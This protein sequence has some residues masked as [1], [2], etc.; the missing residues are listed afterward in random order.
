MDS[1]DL[2]ALRSTDLVIPVM[3]M[4]GVGKSSFITRLADREAGV[5]HGL[6]SFT[7]GIGVYRVK[8]ARRVVYLVDT[9]GFDDT[10][11][12]DVE[13]F[14]ELAFLFGQLYR[15]GARLGGILYLHRITDNRATGSAVRSFNT[16]KSVCGPDAAKFVLLV[17]TMW[18]SIPTDSKLETI[19][20]Q[21]ERELRETEIFWG[22]MSRLGSGMARWPDKENSPLDIVNALA[23]SAIQDGPVI[24]QIQREIVDQKC[25]LEDTTAGR[26]LVEEYAGLSKIFRQELKKLQIDYAEAESLRHDEAAK[27]IQ[28]QKG[29]LEDQ[30]LA[31]EAAEQS[32]RDS[33]E[34]LFE[35]KQEVYRKLHEEAQKE[36]N[37]MEQ[38]LER[39]RK[40][41]QRMRNDI[42]RNT[43]LYD[44]ETQA[45]QDRKAKPSALADR[46]RLD[47][48]YTYMKQGYEELQQETTE[49]LKIMMG[50]V[51]R[52]ERQQ[53]LKRNAMPILGILAGIAAIAAGAAT[54][55]LPV[56]TLGVSICATAIS[57]LKTKKREKPEKKKEDEEE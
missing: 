45:Y 39:Y 55:Q 53:L 11:R 50:K 25:P 21:R 18:D 24:L 38:R 17:T 41:C 7:T 2:L 19:A 14:K 3:G 48:F 4:T 37:D 31:V 27:A 46:R 47:E 34:A 28:A 29:S 8:S 56:V 22:S 23:D 44:S 54:V 43:E 10:S 20:L 30:I 6:V 26:E 12:T 1:G 49:K 33:V 5:G 16:L 32:L 57:K 40:E 42:R 51:N 15:N 9:P 52:E 13:I 36:E 35:E